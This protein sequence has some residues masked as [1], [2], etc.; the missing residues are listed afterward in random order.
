M[1]SPLFALSIVRQE[2]NKQILYCLIVRLFWILSIIY[3]RIKLTDFSVSPTVFILTHKYEIPD[4]K[5]D[6]F[7]YEILTFF[8]LLYRV[9]TEKQPFFIFHKNEKKPG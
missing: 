8:R 7:A 1:T 9:T 6:Q 3:P 5:G 2:T 4:E